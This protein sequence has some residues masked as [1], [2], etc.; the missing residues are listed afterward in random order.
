MDRTVA[1]IGAGVMGRRLAGHFLRNGFAVALVDPDN[2]AIESAKH[3][4]TESG[5][6]LRS[7]VLAGQIGALDESWRACPLVIEAVP[8]RIA[9]KQAVI[10]ALE[11]FFAPDSL[12]ASNTSGLTTAQLAEGMAHPERLAIAHFFNP[13]D[14]I[15]V[16]EL[17]GAAQMPPE[18]LEGLAA[19]LRASGKI[20]ALLRRELPGFVANRIQH[21]LMRECFHLVAEGVADP[22]TIDDVIRYSIGVRMALAGPFEQRDLN[23]L[24]TH[25]NI[26]GYLYPELAAD[27]EPPALLRETV[28]RGA[29]GRKAGRGF[30]EWTAGRESRAEAM[31]IALA[32]VVGESRAL[33]GTGNEEE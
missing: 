6:D 27:P 30:Y 14:L 28:A 26:A 33:D 23:G 21:A 11:A 22:A 20:P 24:D 5:L 13:A 29:L 32:R 16:V 3:L 4:L 15:P 8:E 2:Q 18:R 17:I 1:I 25:L 10:G 9:L 31:E 12:I 19:I 7:L